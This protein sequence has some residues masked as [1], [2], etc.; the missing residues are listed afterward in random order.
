[1]EAATAQ[2]HRFAQEF[3]KGVVNKVDANAKKVAIKHEDLKSLDMPAMTTVFRKRSARPTAIALQ[4][5]LKI[6]YRRVR[7]GC[8]LSR[9]GPMLRSDG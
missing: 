2:R 6:D 1:M 9:Q 4:R 8:S 3:T 7:P 5:R